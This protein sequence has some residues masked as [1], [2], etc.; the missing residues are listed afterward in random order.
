MSQFTDI[1]TGNLEISRELIKKILEICN[2]VEQCG[3]I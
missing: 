2:R 1:T 3:K